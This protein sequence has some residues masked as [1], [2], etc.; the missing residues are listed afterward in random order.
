MRAVTWA[1]GVIPMPAQ[2]RQQLVSGGVFPVVALEA[3]IASVCVVLLPRN[4]VHGRQARVR[5][6]G[7]RVKERGARVREGGARVR[8]ARGEVKGGW[9]EGKGGKGQD[10]EMDDGISFLRNSR[11]GGNIAQWG[12]IALSRKNRGW[13]AAE[14]TGWCRSGRCCPH[15]GRKTIYSVRDSGATL[16][17]FPSDI[18]EEALQS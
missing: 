13:M 16:Q 4:L 2:S 8:D 12:V 14:G 15:V 9:D 11:I 7:A 3:I 10:T 1:E 5:E 6:G 18:D 17:N